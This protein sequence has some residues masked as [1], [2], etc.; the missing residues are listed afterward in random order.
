MLQHSIHQGKVYIITDNFYPKKLN[1]YSCFT[2][3]NINIKTT[4]NNDICVFS[5]KQSAINTLATCQYKGYE[6]HSID[7]EELEK[8][9]DCFDLKMMFQ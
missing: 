5:T 4:K 8:I 7:H 2:L 6:V 1:N 3:T 9:C